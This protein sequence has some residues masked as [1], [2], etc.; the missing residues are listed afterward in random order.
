VSRSERSRVGS[1]QRAIGGSVPTCIQERESSPRGVAK[2]RERALWGRGINR[3]SSCGLR[4]E[5]DPDTS[6]MRH[7]HHR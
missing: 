4:S 6:V 3:K 7:S 2:R 5:I 1:K